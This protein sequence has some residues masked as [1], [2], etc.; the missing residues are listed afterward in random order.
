MNLQE[1]N[2]GKANE[3]AQK[4]MKMADLDGNGTID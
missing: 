1:F 4:W 3:F 2:E